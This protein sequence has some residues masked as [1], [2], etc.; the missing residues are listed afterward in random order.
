MLLNKQL[1][2]R[3]LSTLSPYSRK[4]GPFGPNMSV[5]AKGVSRGV[6]N[7]AFSVSPD[8]FRAFDFVLFFFFFCIGRGKP[9]LVTNHHWGT[10]RTIANRY[11]GMLRTITNRYRGM[12]KTITNRYWGML[13]TVTNRCWG[14][15]SAITNC[16]WG[17][18][19]TTTNRCW[20]MLR[21][22]TSRCWGMLRTV[23]N[24]VSRD[25]ER[26][27]KTVIEGR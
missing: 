23:H 14:M 13:R 17:S 19:R 8:R 26:H 21:T 7:I 5:C 15:L 27:Y 20:G 2:V 24:P 1:S 22:A 4:P 18:L 12:L 9:F 6:H 16:Y 25:V 10:S 3:F 11:W